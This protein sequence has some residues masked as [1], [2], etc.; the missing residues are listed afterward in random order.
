MNDVLDRLIA[1]YENLRPDTLG[2]LREL[3]ATDARFK[4][5]FNEVIGHEA[6]VRIFEHMFANLESP[7]FMVTARTDG[8]SRAALEW[9]F[10]FVMS[11]RS[12]EV[13]GASVL[14]FGSDGRVNVHRDYWDPA[15]ELYTKLPGVGAVF[16]WLRRRMSATSS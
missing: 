14:V 2:E 6:I 10:F 11:G 16:R 13:H 3:Y 12:L 15:E 1:F 7:R 8:D 4:D 5:P 9:T